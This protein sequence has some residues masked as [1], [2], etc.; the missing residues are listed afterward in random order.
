MSPAPTTKGFTVAQK[1]QVLLVDDVDGSEASES[2]SFGFDGTTYELDLSEK[3]AKK[4][5][6][7]LGPWIKAARKTGGTRR[8][9]KTSSNLDLKAVRAWGRVQQDRAVQPRP[10]T[11]QRHQAVQSRRE[12]TYP[13]R[14]RTKGAA[15]VVG[16]A[17]SSVRRKVLGPSS[18]ALGAGSIDAALDCRRA[19][20]CRGWTQANRPTMQTQQGPIRARYMARRSVPPVSGSGPSNPAHHSSILDGHRV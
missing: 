17:L 16:A 8:P 1:V 3:N 18:P 20:A 7:E 2:V 15:P 14:C 5:R 13:W 10:R 11:G 4:L 12:L 6:D 9:T 19:W